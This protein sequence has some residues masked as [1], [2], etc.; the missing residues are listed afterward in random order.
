[1]IIQTSSDMED[2][3]QKMGA[4]LKGGEVIELIGDIG[5][6]KTTFVHGLAKG[7][8]VT[9]NVTSPSFT[10]NCN[11]P[12]RDN[13]MLRHYDFYRLND[14]GIMSMEIAEAVND[15]QAIIVIEWGDSIRNVLPDQH[16]TI[17]IAYLAESGRQVTINL[18]ENSS[19]LSS[20]LEPKS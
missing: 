9:D 14:P 12:G 16:I 15:Q 13:L 5:A 2:L 17:N 3:G 19:H 18:P 10:I 8:G 6:G 11:Y 1:M 7:L 20:I 4:L